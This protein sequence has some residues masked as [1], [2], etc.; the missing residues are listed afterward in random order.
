[1]IIDLTDQRKR[2]LN[3]LTA[4]KKPRNIFNKCD[5]ENK[6]ESKF[7]YE[8]SELIAKRMKPFQDEDNNKDAIAIFCK[9]ASPEKVTILKKIN[10]SRITVARKIKESSTQIQ[11]EISKVCVD[12]EFYSL[13]IDESTDVSDTA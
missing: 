5:S 4:L 10:L 9:N 13:A 6:I 7:S 1:M 8:I 3:S 11:N 12:L 2:K